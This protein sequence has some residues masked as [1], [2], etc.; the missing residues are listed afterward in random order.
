MSFHFSVLSA[1][2]IQTNFLIVFLAKME[3]LGVSGTWTWY[4]FMRCQ[5]YDLDDK[6]FITLRLLLKLFTSS[7]RNVSKSFNVCSRSHGTFVQNLRGVWVLR[8]FTHKIF[9][10]PHVD[11]PTTV[12]F[13]TKTF[14]V[15]LIFSSNYV[16]SFVTFK[17]FKNWGFGE[18]KL[19]CSL[20]QN[21]QLTEPLNEIVW[22]NNSRN[23]YQTKIVVEAQSEHF[24]S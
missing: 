3:L 12:E 5:Q 14:Q 15:F 6:L 16:D 9:K 1:F 13:S 17:G 21:L 19:A 20:R 24:V 7:R 22:T 8:K 2:K 18:I 10:L 4:P 23:C 11:S